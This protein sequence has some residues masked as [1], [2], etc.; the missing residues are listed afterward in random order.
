MLNNINNYILLI[1]INTMGRGA[2]A[3]HAAYNASGTQG[4]S[5][6]NEIKENEDIHSVFITQNDTSRQILHGH[7]I[8]EM[9]C[10]GKSEGITSERYKIFTPDENSDM[11]GDVYLNFEMDSEINEFTFVDAANGNNPI[12]MYRFTEESRTLDLKLA[13]SELK[14]LDVNLN[15]NQIPSVIDHQNLGDLGFEVIN[16]TKF[17]K[18]NTAVYQF[19]VGKGDSSSNSCNI[20]WRVY[21]TNNWRKLL[22]S[23]LKE[24]NCVNVEPHTN[25]GDGIAI[26]GGVPHSIESMTATAVATITDGSV[27]G[28]TYTLPFAGAY[29]SPPIV[30]ISAPEGEGGI[31]ATAVVPVIHRG[32]FAGGIIVTNGGSGYTSVPTV[33][34]APPPG[35]NPL[36][37]I[38]MNYIRDNDY[39]IT[40]LSFNTFPDFPLNSSENS[41]Y[42]VVYTLE[43]YG[44]GE[45][46]VSGATTNASDKTNVI[47]TSYPDE[48]E[49]TFE[50]VE[51]DGHSMDA[52]VSSSFSNAGGESFISLA[53]KSE[54][55]LGI[56]SNGK[57]IR[58][59]DKGKN[60]K[61]VE[62]FYHGPGNGGYYYNDNFNYYIPS[63][64][65]VVS[66][67]SGKWIAIGK[68]GV[69]D[70]DE[71]ESK[72]YRQFVFI[73]EDV[74]V[75]WAPVL[76][77]KY[78][79]TWPQDYY[80]VSQRTF[81]KEI[82]EYLQPHLIQSN[83]ILEIP[84]KVSADVFDTAGSSYS[85]SVIIPAIIPF[86]DKFWAFIPGSFQFPEVTGEFDYEY[87]GVANDRKLRIYYG[88]NT[89]NGVITCTKMEEWDN[90]YGFYGE[91]SSETRT[92]LFNGI[93]PRSIKYA[94]RDLLIGVFSN[95]NGDPIQSTHA[96]RFK[97]SLDGITWDDITINE[98]DTISS[99]LGFVVS[100]SASAVV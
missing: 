20:A 32:Y 49:F 26:F 10:A 89:N 6:T 23:L 37:F 51:L 43:Y 90:K 81:Y 83:G 78:G 36:F 31:T 41:Y 21:G 72:K 38:Y 75:S 22:F 40:D 91:Q 39:G 66:D 57:L 9:T 30:T 33:T 68:Q 65:Y 95:I 28:I 45:I 74:G 1:L 14:S 3:A 47:I 2:H 12:D 60:W 69:L 53:D 8:S 54:I 64:D 25:S 4:I 76:L 94:Y 18:T 85:H 55:L 48:T 92:T 97:K 24:V 35:Y 77:E 71:D 62:T 52:A 86:T 27:T 19:I 67:N 93:Y 16:Q 42:E 80:Y 59:Y 98:S 61:N 15:T 46:I 96:Y 50:K 44:P 29:T 13:G 73:S 11:L 58:S 34:I 99:I 17:I 63:L 87:I 88:S 5:V 70:P 56:D 84:F 82:V 7:N 79:H 100:F